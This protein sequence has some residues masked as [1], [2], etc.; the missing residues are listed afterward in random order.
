MVNAF[1]CIVRSSNGGTRPNTSWKA[2]IDEVKCD[3]ANPDSEA[4]GGA[5]SY[6]EATI[7]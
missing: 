7:S 6:A 5:V 2:L 3:L 1:V 4:G